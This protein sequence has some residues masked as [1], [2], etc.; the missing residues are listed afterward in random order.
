[1][2][3]ARGLV[4]PTPPSAEEQERHALT[5][6]PYARWCTTWV[7]SR[8]R[9]DA[10]HTMKLGEGIEVIQCDYTLFKTGEEDDKL[11]PILIGIMVSTGYAYG[12][13][14]LGKG[15]ANDRALV[16]DMANWLLEASMVGK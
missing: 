6:V 13:A 5:H 15:A 3:K 2:R 1:M 12:G 10:H 16:K 11:C 4:M 9:D 7:E 14:A 8:A